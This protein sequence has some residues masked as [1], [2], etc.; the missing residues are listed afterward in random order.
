MHSIF[1]I[2]ELLEYILSLIPR[3]IIIPCALTNKSFYNAIEIDYDQENIA[4]TGDMFSLLK[5]PYYPNVVLN[6]A[7]LHNNIEIIDYLL[8]KQPTLIKN[9]V[10]CQTIGYMGNENLINKIDI[11]SNLFDYITMGICEGKHVNLLEKYNCSK[12]LHSM[13]KG[14]YKSD[15]IIMKQK[16]KE[17]LKNDTF[18]ITYVNNFT[19]AKI[20]GKCASKNVDNIITFIKKSIE[21]SNI[22]NYHSYICDGLIEGGHYDIFVWLENEYPIKKYNCCYHEYLNQL[23][24]SNNL[25]MFRYIILN[26]VDPDDLAYPERYRDD[27]G[28][29]L[30]DTAEHCIEYDRT[31]MAKIL[32]QNVMFDEDFKDYLIDYIDCA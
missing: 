11:S 30:Y 1:I 21:N 26:N 29:M 25:K 18:Y 10:I 31:E 28:M 8:K 14:T 27:K 12:F 19:S 15:S 13:I 20:I 23:V 2:K 7:V 3:N 16:M 4:K 9:K 22:H 6:I 5:I 32:L 17:L 24:R